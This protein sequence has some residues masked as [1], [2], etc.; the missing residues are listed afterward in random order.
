MV[1]NRENILLQWGHRFKSKLGSG[2]AT[3]IF[4]ITFNAV[5]SIV[6]GNYYTQ[7]SNMDCPTIYDVTTTNFKYGTVSA[8][9]YG[10]YWISIGY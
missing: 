2:A 1:I 9:W 5:Y 3:I 7:T 6:I 8:N 4:P 10:L